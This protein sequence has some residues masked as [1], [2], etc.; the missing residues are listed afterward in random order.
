MRFIRLIFAILVAHALAAPFVPLDVDAER[1]TGAPS[2]RVV[3]RFASAETAQEFA[4]LRGLTYDGPAHPGSPFYVFHVHEHSAM[5]SEAGEPLEMEPVVRRFPRG[6]S[7]PESAHFRREVTGEERQWNLH[8]DSFY[9][10]HRIHINAREAWQM[11]YTGRGVK[12]LLV[13]DGVQADHKDIDGAVIASCSGS[14]IPDAPDPDDFQPAVDARGRIDEWHGTACASI[15]AG[16]ND[17]EQYCG[18]GVAFE[19]KLCVRKILDG[20]HEVVDSKE[21]LAFDCAS[22]DVMSV[23]YGPDDTAHQLVAPGQSAQYAL[24]RMATEARRG[25]GVSI[26]WA[27]GNGGDSYNMDTANGDGYANSIY[28]N[29]VGA[30]ND[31]RTVAY[32]SEPGENIMFAAPSNGG[33]NGIYCAFATGSKMECFGGM[34]GTSAAAPELA[35]LAALVLSAVPTLTA[36]Q[37]QHVLILSTQERMKDEAIYSRDHD[38]GGFFLG[39]NRDK[40]PWVVSKSGLAHSALIGF[41]VPDAARAIRVAKRTDMYWKNLPVQ[42][43]AAKA[44][45]VGDGQLPAGNTLIFDVDVAAMRELVFLERVQLHVSLDAPAQ[46][47]TIRIEVESPGGTTSAVWTETKHFQTNMRWVFSSVKFWNERVAGSWKVRVINTGDMRAAIHSLTLTFHGFADVLTG[48]SDG[49]LHDPIF[50]PGQT[51]SDMRELL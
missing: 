29:A 6:I 47:K 49:L 4:R 2:N 34:G 40:F 41:G 5:R 38:D 31:A 37:L 19:S 25:L 15:I 43:A 33:T 44:V 24:Y 10:P 32:Y 8:H 27:G 28:V 51:T 14:M 21:A 42:H 22:C 12:V 35:G 39:N 16:R 48:R 26:F 46:I 1:G 11:G 20:R 50:V 9:G 45:R 17:S 30:V 36:R 23:S 7:D 18:V 3:R 13:D